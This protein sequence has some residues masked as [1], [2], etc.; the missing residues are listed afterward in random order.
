MSYGVLILC[1]LLVRSTTLEAHYTD[2]GVFPL[3]V[4]NS[5]GLPFGISF[6]ALNGSFTYQAVLFFL[7]ALAAIALII[8][9]RTRFATLAC[10]LFMMSLHNRNF[11]LLNGGDTWM[12][13][14]LF[15]AIFLPWGERW[16]LDAGPRKDCQTDEVCSAATVGFVV[17]VFLVYWMAGIFKTGAAWWS[18]GSAIHLTMALAEWNGDLAYY[19]LFYPNLM[20]SLT[21]VILAFELVGPF[22]LV[23]PLFWGPLRTFTVLGF[24]GFHVGLAIFIEIGLFPFVGI[25]TVAALIPGWAWES[26]WMAKLSARLDRF[27]QL[28][29]VRMPVSPQRSLRT[30]SSRLSLV[31]FCITFYVVYWTMGTWR[32]DLGPSPELQV[33]G[34]LL[35]IDQ[36]WGLFAPEPPR[37]HSWFVAEGVLADGRR[38]DLIRDGAPLD[39]SCPVSSSVYKNQRWKR[40]YVGEASEVGGFTREPH[41]RYLYRRWTPRFPGLV[42]IELFRMTQSS[43]LNHLDA[44]PSRI[45]LLKVRRDEL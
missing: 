31:L 7:N 27:W 19:L 34:H 17:Q 18:E 4:Y 41:I 8:G 37:V 42:S 5:V 16:S 39:W 12:R 44:E 29:T 14:M 11:L 25:F 2:Q 32:E 35:R 3:Q 23:S 30:L 13:I 24:I 26:R 40:F 36:Y 9:W 10:W 20:K 15:W 6:H 45:S 43:F 33:P 21:F 1:D 28:A 38:I 22:L